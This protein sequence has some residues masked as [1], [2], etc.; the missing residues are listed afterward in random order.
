ML[1]A[2]ASAAIRALGA[3]QSTGSSMLTSDAAVRCPLPLADP[4]R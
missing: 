4:H 3:D 1:A 2:R